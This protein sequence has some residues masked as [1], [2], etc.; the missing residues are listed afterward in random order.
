MSNQQRPIE[1]RREL[2]KQIRKWENQDKE[3]RDR[4]WREAQERKEK[5]TRENWQKKF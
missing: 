1:S 5:T 4:R 2:E 3:D